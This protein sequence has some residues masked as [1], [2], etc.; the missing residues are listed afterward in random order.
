MWVR[1][2]VRKGVYQRVNEKIKYSPI[3]YGYLKHGTYG[4]TVFG[5]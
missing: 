4:I 5:L 3:Y 1:M 2:K